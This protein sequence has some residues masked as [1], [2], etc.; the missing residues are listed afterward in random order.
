M[1]GKPGGT[2]GCMTGTRRIC[3][4]RGVFEAS[5]VVM[6]HTAWKR[7]ADKHAKR[8]SEL[9]DAHVE[10]RARHEK[11]PVADFL[12]E[13]YRFRMAHLRAWSPG[14]GVELEIDGPLE[15]HGVVTDFWMPVGEG[16]VRLDPGRIPAHRQDGFRYIRELL[17]RTADRPPLYGCAGMHEWA[18]VYG[19]GAVRHGNVPLR[20]SRRDIDRTVED[21]GPRCTHFD[22][23]RFFTE[24][25][26]PL[27]AAS[28]ARENALAIEQPG[29]LHANMDLYKWA[30]KGWPW[31]A[32]ELIVD[33]L[34]LA[35]DIRMLDMRASPYDLRARGLSPVCVETPEGRAEYAE[36]QRGFFGRAQELRRQLIGAWDG[37]LSQCGEHSDDIRRVAP[38]KSI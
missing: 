22:A 7:A 3:R 8:V 26:K 27:N 18:M 1:D 4:V 24:P 11:D 6:T 10:R 12:F 23:F 31:I 29:C 14:L 35:F 19:G 20:L 16:R 28:L 32:S 30:Y 15:P 21:V 13:Y 38:P 2:N 9:V 5:M 25:A 36:R 17:V 34:A 37:V 33:G